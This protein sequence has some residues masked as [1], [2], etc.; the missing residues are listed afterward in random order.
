MSIIKIF[1]RYGS[2]THLSEELLDFFVKSGSTLREDFFA[3]C[4][5]TAKDLIP[6]LTSDDFAKQYRLE[7]LVSTN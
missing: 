6:Q 2:A 5:S 7:K 4:N 1:V 3:A